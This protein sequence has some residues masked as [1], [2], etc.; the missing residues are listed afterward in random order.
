MAH[1]LLAHPDADVRRALRAALEPA[2]HVADETGDAAEVAELVAHAAAIQDP[3]D[4]LLVAGPDWARTLE[5]ARRDHAVVLLGAPRETDP[6][7][8]VGTLD[9]AG[10]PR[11][12]LAT[13]LAVRERYLGR[14][15]TWEHA[16]AY[17]SSLGATQAAEEVDRWRARVPG[18]VAGAA[19][20]EA[21]IARALDALDAN[22]T[23]ELSDTE[24][25]PLLAPLSAYQATPSFWV[26]LRECHAHHRI[27][28]LS[29]LH[30]LRRIDRDRLAHGRA[31][32]GG[33]F[34]LDVDATHRLF[35]RW[36]NDR[37]VL[38]D[39][40]PADQAEAT[41]ERLTHALEAPGELV[42]ASPAAI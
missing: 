20:S 25:P 27:R 11:A 12:A 28:C 40:V 5:P 2:G 10:D 37:R 7:E 6:R 19:G 33:H 42:G 35:F 26:A 15:A 14:L 9:P 8:V 4:L 23:R 24:L 16:L 29:L 38:E 31:L 17:L 21:D 3:Y 32:P 22:C 1:L 18:A 39:F 30:A 34:E 36:S 41:R 13:A